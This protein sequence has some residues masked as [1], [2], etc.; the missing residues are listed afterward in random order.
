MN[1]RENTLRA[2]RF[3][4]PDNIPMV[5]HINASC[6]THYP[7]GT[8]FDLMEEYTRLFPLFQRPKN[9]KPEITYG[10]CQ[11]KNEPYLDPWLCEWKTTEDGITGSVHVHPLAKWDNFN[12]YTAPDP[13]KTNGITPVDWGQFYIEMESKRSKGELLVAGLPHGHTFLRLQDIRGYENVLYDMMDERPELDTLLGMVSDFNYSLVQKILKGKPDIM[14]YPEDLGMQA[15]PMITPD[16]F[17]KYIK[18]V[19]TRLM[20]PAKNIGTIVHMHSD[21]DI[22]TLAKDMIEGG[23]DVLNLQDLVNGIEWIRDNFRGKLCIDLDIDRQSITRFGTPEEIDQHIHN[24]I[25]QI[26]TKDGGLLLIYGL[27]PGVPVENI[28]A[29]MQAMEKYMDFFN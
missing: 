20:K 10:L 13:E 7:A 4:K 23:I 5:F 14:S 19:Y 18:S 29:L 17:K 27:Y 1:A 24:C 26:G 28:R 9:V 16:A 6:W 21:G 3:E 2:I 15:G 11:K 22:R 12:N 8:L 25:K